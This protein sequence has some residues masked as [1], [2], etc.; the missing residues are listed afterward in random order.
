MK[1]PFLS[2]FL[3]LFILGCS[4]SQNEI[5]GEISV[6][7][8]QPNLKIINGLNVEIYYAA[9]D[10]DFAAVIDWVKSSTETNRIDPGKSVSF[11]TSMIQ[12]YEMGDKIQVFYWT[13]DEAI[14]GYKIVE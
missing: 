10:S 9:L 12:E 14:S 4:T 3:F 6:V 13:E 2:A 7:L 11:L 8:E 1:K 5:E